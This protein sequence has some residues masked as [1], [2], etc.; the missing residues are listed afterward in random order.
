MDALRSPDRVVKFSPVIDT[1]AL[2]ESGVETVLGPKVVEVVEV[3]GV[4][5][6]TV[7]T[8]T[9]TT[10]TVTTAGALSVNNPGT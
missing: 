10:G 1:V 5:T 6:G 8:G 4:T 3:I 7:T 9:V 2:N